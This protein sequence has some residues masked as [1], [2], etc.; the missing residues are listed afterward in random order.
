MAHEPIPFLMFEG[1]AEEA[2]R[3]YTTLFPDSAITHIE[4]YG[5]GEQGAEGKVRRAEFTLNGQKFMCIDSPIK[6]EFG[7]TPALS[8]F[9][10][11]ADENEL[12]HYF[13]VLA[14]GGAVLM[15]ID[16]YGFSRLFAWLNDRF[17]V[18]WQLNVW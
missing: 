11:C 17:G 4:R 7:F 14:D 9:V 13:A 12:R 3:M 15:P 1:C 6:H 2:M 18:S 16:D 10:E 5:P 8:L